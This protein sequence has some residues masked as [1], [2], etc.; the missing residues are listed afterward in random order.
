MAFHFPL[1]LPLL[2]S[3][4]SSFRSFL[5][6]AQFR[7][8][9][10]GSGQA[11]M[12]SVKKRQ[13]RAL[14]MSSCLRW[15]R[16]L[17]CAVLCAGFGLGAQKSQEA[18][19]TLADGAHD[20][21]FARRTAAVNALGLLPDDSTAIAMAEGALKDSAPEV[22]SAAA[23]ALGEMRASGSFLKL[24]K[25][26]DDKDPSVALAAAHS[27]HLLQDKRAYEVYYEI[28]LGE[29]KSGPS[30]IA[31]QEKLL[32]DRKKLAEMGFEEGIGFV[33]FAG[34]GWGAIKTLHQD[35]SSQVRA[36]A[37]QVLVDDPDPRS[38]RALVKGA[39]DKSWI[40]RA[41]CLNATARRGDPSLLKEVEACLYDQKDVVRFTAAAAII[42]LTTDLQDAQPIADPGPETPPA[43]PSGVTKKR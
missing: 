40:V 24:E 43:A 38:G 1:Y 10:Y 6:I 32:R 41:A 7:R 21:S 29:R 14:S 9:I 36:A 34:I 17:L 27:L 30:L 2:D 19:K 33:P 22:R 37:A 16:A 25:A 26:L 15:Y 28:L 3:K 13:R 5:L 42:R 4:R 18:W 35:D 31:A 8:W 20:K 11:R 12:F 23:T 39:A